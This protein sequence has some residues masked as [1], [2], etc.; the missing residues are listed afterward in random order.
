VQVALLVQQCACWQ[1]TNAEV[2]SYLQYFIKDVGWRG[3]QA[4]RKAWKANLVKQLT[5]TS[6]TA[7][8]GR[9]YR[10]CG[11]APSPSSCEVG[12]QS[13]PYK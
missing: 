4:R 7:A 10:I 8:S 9:R 6:F 12:I 2:L 5:K 11:G 13:T 1:L 3:L